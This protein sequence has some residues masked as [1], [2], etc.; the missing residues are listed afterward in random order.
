MIELKFECS[1]L[2]QL[3]ETK[4]RIMELEGLE[5]FN[6]GIYEAIVD[7]SESYIGELMD[8]LQ[9]ELASLDAYGFGEK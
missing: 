4:L 8:F 2:E 5:K 3:I 6:L 9:S 1:I 7:F